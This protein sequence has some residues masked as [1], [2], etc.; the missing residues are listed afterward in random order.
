MEFSTG[1]AQEGVCHGSPMGSLTVTGSVLEA[2]S[3]PQ[4]ADGNRLGHPRAGMVEEYIYNP[5]Y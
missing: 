4:G 5:G 1:I 2:Q 3:T